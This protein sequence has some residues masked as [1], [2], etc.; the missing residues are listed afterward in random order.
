MNKTKRQDLPAHSSSGSNAS[1]S[2]QLWVVATPIGNLDDL[3]P[4]G[5]K[6]LAEADFILCEDTRQ[7]AKL[8]AGIGETYSMSRL[9]RMDAHTPE[10][11]LSRWVSRMAQGERLALITDAGTPAISD[12]G[13][14]LVK[15]ALRA[16][17]QVVPVPGPS[18]VP[19][20]L[21]VCGFGETAFTFR[22]FFPRKDSDQRAELK[23]AAG[24]LGVQVNVWFES[25]QRIGSTLKSIASQ[26][27]EVE[28]VAAKELT[29]V[30]EK[31]FQGSAV[32]T[33]ESV[34][35]ELKREGSL[36]EWVFAI[37]FPAIQDGSVDSKLLPESEVLSKSLQ[38]MFDA[39]VS[40]SEAAKRVSQRFGAP[41]K[42]VYDLALKISGKKSD[43]KSD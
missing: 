12:P 7:G 34:D 22:G 31:I 39:G 17:I 13:A 8:L 26:Y 18:A 35:L 25:P 1:T 23:R 4:R 41:K 5:K 29:K 6:A 36:G 16:G 37:R 21:S 40:A 32:D 11:Q 19:T 42:T 33:A 10:A 14:A 28:L 15:Q 27:P 2:G 3:S 30:Y 9:E 38:C 20:L 43:Q 24:S